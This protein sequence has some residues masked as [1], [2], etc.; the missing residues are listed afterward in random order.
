MRYPLNQ[1]CYIAG[2]LLLFLT[3]TE[4]IRLAAVLPRSRRTAAVVTKVRPAVPADWSR[5]KATGFWKRKNSSLMAFVT[6]TVEGR[7]YFS[8]N[9]IP[10]PSGTD[11][12]AMIKIRYAVHFPDMI[13][14]RSFFRLLLFAVLS[15][16]F[17]LLGFLL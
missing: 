15:L 1:L 11:V 17:F 2:I 13:V 6:Y 8:R 3:L 16:L 9:E 4:I 10:V 14:E 12:G 7:N 5:R